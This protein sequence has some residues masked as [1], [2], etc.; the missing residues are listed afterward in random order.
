MAKLLSVIIPARSEEFLQNTI[1]DVFK[2]LEADTEVLVGLDG[3]D[4]ELQKR[5]NLKIF[6]ESSP[7]G[8]RAMQNALARQSD[9][10]YLLKLDAHVSLSQGFDRV[11]LEIMEA[12][13]DIVLV[14]AFTNLWV[15]NWVCPQGHR[16]YQG[17][18]DKCSQCEETKL[19]KEIV[20]KNNTKVYSDFR[21]NDDL[22][23][24][25]G[26]LENYEMFHPVQAIQGS[27]FCVSRENYWKWNLCDESWGSWGSQGYEIWKKVQNNGSKTF[28]TRKAF[29]GH[30][31]R[32]V[33]E[34]PYE[35]DM[36]QVDMAYQKS[37]ELFAK[38]V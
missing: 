4:K 11:M 30:F 27:G 3:W 32:K 6:H 8:Q 13:P 35:R 20:W 15:Y 9:A 34:F 5:P 19:E 25:Y 1:D 16:T 23:F 14:P 2:H 31:F 21:F 17:K 36:K 33:D 29:M 7:I 28:V 12:N 38:S 22:I 26:D 24:E 10:K 37:K 18:V